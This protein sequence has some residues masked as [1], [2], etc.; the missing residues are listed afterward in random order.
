MLGGQLGRCCAMTRLAEQAGSS[1]GVEQVR[2]GE[3][4]VD[5]VNG[6]DGVNRVFC[7]ED[8]IETFWQRK[9]TRLLG[10]SGI[11]GGKAERVF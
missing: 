6:V 8:S 11:L 4:R 2:Y 7:Q 9:V 10:E 5:R 3:R 1:V